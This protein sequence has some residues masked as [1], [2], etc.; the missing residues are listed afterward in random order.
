MGFAAQA[1]Y[2]SAVNLHKA[3]MTSICEALNRPMR[4][5]HPE[6]ATALAAKADLPA[7]GVAVDEYARVVVENDAGKVY[8]GSPWPAGKRAAGIVLPAPVQAAD[9]VPW[10]SLGRDMAFAKLQSSILSAAEAVQA[11][12]LHSETLPEQQAIMLSAGGPG[13]GTCWTAMHKS[14][15]ELPEN[16]QWRMATALRLGA[17]RDVGPRSTCA[18]RHRWGHVRA[19]SGDEPVP[20][21][22]LQVRRSQDQTAPRSS[23]H[24]TQA[25]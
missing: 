15:T 24:L 2:W 18:P 13:T 17:T 12:K 21:V 7:T 22:L 3:V 8:E 10:K 14:P 19:I 11:A 1:T 9:S 6:E 23:A 4:E 25:H 16:A 5:P 20:P